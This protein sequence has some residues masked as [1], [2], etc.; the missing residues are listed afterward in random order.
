MAQKWAWYNLA[1][2]GLTVAVVGALLPVLGPGAHGGFGLL[3][4]LG[5]GPLLFRRRRDGVVWDERDEAIR[6]RAVA[7]AFAVFWLAFVA[8]CVGLPAFYGWEGRVPVGLV[9]ASVF[10]GVALIYGVMSVATLVQYRGGPVD[11]V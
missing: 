2:V 3:G 6:R 1:V 10:A 9:Q 4:L 7:V 5:F 11:G 8:V